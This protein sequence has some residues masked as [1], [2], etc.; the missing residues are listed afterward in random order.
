MAAADKFIKVAQLGSQVQEFFV[1]N[2]T[3]VQGALEM[4]GLSWEGH[5]VRVNGAPAGLDR[6]MEDT[7]VLTLVPEIKGGVA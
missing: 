1:R 3:T 6:V 4:A 2:G 5:S 7:E